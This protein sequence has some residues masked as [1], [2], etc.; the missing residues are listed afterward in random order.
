[1]PTVNAYHYLGGAITTTTATIIPTKLIAKPGRAQKRS[2]NAAMANAFRAGGS[3]TTKTTAA[4][5][6]TKTILCAPTGPANRISLPVKPL[7]ES[8]YQML[9]VVTIR[10]IVWTDQTRSLVSTSRVRPKR[11]LVTTTNVSPKGGFAMETTTAATEPT[12]LDALHTPVP[13]QSLPV[14]MEFAFRI[15]GTAMEMSTAVMDQM[16]PIAPPQFQP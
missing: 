11:S 12:R 10:K 8:A 14:R 7:P 5:I 6:L 15:V 16:R 3:A 4:T 9:G 2:S 13:H 1:M